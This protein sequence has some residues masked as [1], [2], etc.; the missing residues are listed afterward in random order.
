MANFIQQRLSAGQSDK[1]PASLPYCRPVRW[2]LMRVGDLPLAFP[3]KSRPRSHEEGLA[4]QTNNSAGLSPRFH[5]MRRRTG[6][7]NSD[8]EAMEQVRGHGKQPHGRGC[9]LMLVR[10]GAI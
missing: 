8:L 5:S 3:Q 9:P 6:I 7:A 1:L 10:I 2:R 4:A